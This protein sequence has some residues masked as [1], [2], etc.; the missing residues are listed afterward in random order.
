MC[1]NVNF[2]LSTVI[3][4]GAEEPSATQLILRP[5]IDKPKHL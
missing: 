4:P 3:A 1:Q 5:G 2:S